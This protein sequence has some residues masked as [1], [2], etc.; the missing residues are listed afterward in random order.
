MWEAYIAYINDNPNRYW[1]KRK[2]YG[3]GWTPAR[4]AGWLAT[5]LFIAIVL[6]VM[7][8]AESKPAVLSEVEG[9]GVVIVCTLVFLI[10]AYRTG[11][12]PAWQWGNPKHDN[13]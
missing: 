12:P 13:H 3:W 4:R 11:E 9:L 5:F 7:T 10:V 6:G 2:L 1:F 8:L